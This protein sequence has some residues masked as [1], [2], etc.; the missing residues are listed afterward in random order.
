[1][2]D[3]HNYLKSTPDDYLKGVYICTGLSSMEELLDDIRNT[4]F[5]CAVVE[6]GDEGW[7]DMLTSEN[8]N[9]TLTFY[10]LE[11]KDNAMAA[12]IKSILDRAKAKGRELLR[13][14]RH[15]AS[16][17]GD[18]CY[19]IDFSNL[20]YFKVGPISMSAYGYCFNLTIVEQ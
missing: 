18:V 15:D 11:R 5:P 12:D 16:D 7:F 13:R 8:E 14:M 17:Y 1:M 9:R 4:V 20:N 2:F 6:V 19:G 10:I 3:L